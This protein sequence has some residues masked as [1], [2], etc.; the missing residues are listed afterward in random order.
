MNNENYNNGTQG[1]QT[2]TI[3]KLGNYI[4]TFAIN[5]FYIN[6]NP[7]DRNEKKVEGVENN[8][9][10]EYYPEFNRTYYE[11]INDIT[12]AQSKANIKIY[13]KDYEK[14]IY[15]MDIN[16]HNTEKE[17][18]WLVAF[19]LNGNKGI[20]SLKVINKYVGVQPN[21]SYCEEIYNLKEKLLMI[22]NQLMMKM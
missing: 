22:H 18:K 8:A 16:S 4:Y 13:I 15:K 20:K 7:I 2:L 21:Y 19:C 9:P 17:K 11:D 6:D 5:P 14:E 1:T 3:E 12:F 10:T